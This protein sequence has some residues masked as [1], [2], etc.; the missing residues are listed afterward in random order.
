MT[1]AFRSF[2]TFTRNG[3]GNVTPSK[4]AGVVDGDGL[5]F[6]FDPVAKSL[7][8]TG[9]TSETATTGFTAGRAIWPYSRRASSEPSSYTFTMPAGGTLSDFPSLM[10][11]FSGADPT[12]L[13]DAQAQ[14]G[15]GTTNTSLTAPS[16]TTTQSNS[17]IICAY[18][19][20]N[21][22]AFTPPAG[23]TTIGTVVGGTSGYNLTACYALQAVAGASGTKIAT[24][25]T[26]S[27]YDSKTYAM[28][29]LNITPAFWNRFVGSLEVD[30]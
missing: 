16:V 17:M 20:N 22:S 2:T 13:L 9:W 7:T 5:L 29:G 10:L 12:T 19:Y 28:R 14:G 26:T 23:M 1:I 4:P 24:I 6:L 8:A 27:P 3:S 21:S 25:G 18:L 30:S 11:A 15:S